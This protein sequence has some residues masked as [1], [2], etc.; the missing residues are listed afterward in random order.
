MTNPLLQYQQH[1]IASNKTFRR[2]LS[3]EEVLS[4]SDG[5]FFATLEKLC[6]MEDLTLTVSGQCFP[7]V[8]RTESQGARIYP[9]STNQEFIDSLSEAATVQ[10]DATNTEQLNTSVDF[11]HN[12]IT[13]KAHLL[14]NAKLCHIA[15]VRIVQAVTGIFIDDYNKRRKLLNGMK[16]RTR[17]MDDSGVKHSKYNKIYLKMQ[18]SYLASTPPALIVLPIMS[19]DDIKGWDGVQPYSALVLPCGEQ[20]QLAAQDVLQNVRECCSEQDVRTALMVLRTFIKDIAESLID[21]NNDVLADFNVVAR[22]T[23]D[24][25][26]VRWKNLVRELRSSAHPS[27]RVPVLRTGINFQTT[28]VAKGTLDV[29]TSCLPDPFLLAMK[30]AI[31]F[32]SH[33]GTKLMPACPSP[34]Q[35]DSDSGPYLED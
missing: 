24:V 1:V 34:V 30:G 2:G 3:A 16:V 19:L 25:S 12:L 31:N 8:R 20:G 14:S 18:R 28:R 17:R 5:D 6:Q 4:R 13:E 29:R 7:N 15:Y 26:A 35:F 9:S 21:T 32:S 22:D 23:T 33:A 27:I 11:V 10:S